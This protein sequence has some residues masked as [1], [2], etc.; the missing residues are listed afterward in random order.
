MTT[1]IQ[2]HINSRIRVN[3]RARR[4]IK[5][6]MDVPVFSI[7]PNPTCMYLTA[8]LKE[9]LVRF[10][11]SIARKQGLCCILGDNG[12]G[13]SSLLRFLATAYES[14][15]NCNVSY[16]SDTRRFKTTFEFLKLI[17]ADFGISPKR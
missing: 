8:S 12:M 10:R 14:D 3:F 4:D 5:T 17:S 1:H 7:S 9:A 13:K 15:T 2:L 11:R 16:F 6:G